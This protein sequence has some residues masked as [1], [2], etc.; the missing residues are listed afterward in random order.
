MPK[1]TRAKV[2]L[3]PDAYKALEVE[4]MLMGVSLKDAASKMILKAAC[5]KCKEILGIMTRPPKVPD[6]PEDPKGQRDP[7]LEGPNG[8]IVTNLSLTEDMKTQKP[9][10]HRRSLEKDDAALTQINP[11]TDIRAFL[12][13]AQR[14]E[15][16]GG[17]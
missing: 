11:L 3:S 10:S 2:T 16:K 17:L 1:D 13:S 9:I 12:L 5:P 15:Q 6:G 4:A 14:A 8:P 7:G